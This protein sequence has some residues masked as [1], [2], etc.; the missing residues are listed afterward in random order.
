VPPPA[1]RRGRHDGGCR[2]VVDWSQSGHISVANAPPTR[3]MGDDSQHGRPFV[4]QVRATGPHTA[5]SAGTAVGMIGGQ[6]V[7]GSS[8]ASP[9]RGDGRQCRRM[10]DPPGPAASVTTNGWTMTMT[11]PPTR[12]AATVRRRQCPMSRASPANRC[13]AKDRSREDHQVPHRMLPITLGPMRAAKGAGLDVR[14]R[15]ASKVVGGEWGH[16]SR[17]RDVGCSGLGDDLKT[18]WTLGAASPRDRQVMNRARQRHR[19]SR[20]FRSRSGS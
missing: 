14:A 11:T 3:R 15:P 12:E 2:T 16:V 10:A 18:T 17:M 5:A 19:P 9:T 13:G 1:E 4:S 7:A 20:P 6:G 8:P